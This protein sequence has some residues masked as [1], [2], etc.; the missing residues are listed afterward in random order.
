VRTAAGGTRSHR[1]GV[2]DADLFGPP[3]ERRET[4]V[5]SERALVAD[6]DEVAPGAR[7]GHVEATLVRDEAEAMLRVA[8]HR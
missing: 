6:E 7:H 3:H 8:S 2:A 1:L 5:V 4:V